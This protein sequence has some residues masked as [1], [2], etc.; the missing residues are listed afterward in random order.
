MQMFLEFI[1]WILQGGVM[2]WWAVGGGGGRGSGVRKAI[3]LLYEAAPLMCIYMP[4]Y[5]FP[6]AL[7]RAPNVL[8]RCQNAK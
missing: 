2:W 5:V 3:L 1:Y 8:S 6:C 7:P 4:V